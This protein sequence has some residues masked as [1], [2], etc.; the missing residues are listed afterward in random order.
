[1][2]KIK[3]QKKTVKKE[4]VQKPKKF[5]R[6]IEFWVVQQITNEDGDTGDQCIAKFDNYEMAEAYA[7][8]YEGKMD[9]F[10]RGFLPINIKKVFIDERMFKNG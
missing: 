3:K 1:M 5:E 7:L 9:Y 10:Q 6:K 8:R 2:T 4:A